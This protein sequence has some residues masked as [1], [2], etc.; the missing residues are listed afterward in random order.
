[1]QAM[2][3]L[4]L[5]S[6]CPTLATAESAKVGLAFCPCVGF[7]IFCANLRWLSDMD[8]K[9]GL[10]AFTTLAYV[11]AIDGAGGFRIPKFPQGQPLLLWHNTM[12][13]TFTQR[14][15][16]EGAYPP[17]GL[18]PQ[19]NCRVFEH[20][21]VGRPSRLLHHVSVDRAQKLLVCPKRT[22][23]GCKRTNRRQNV[24]ATQ[25]THGRRKRMSER[26]SFRRN[27]LRRRRG[28]D[29]GAESRHYTIT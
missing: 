10:T 27:F 26:R 3:Q 8:Q 4:M 28:C 6:Y 17:P 29:F 2:V 13:L 16:G 9:M 11:Q 1:M 25:H 18:K 14:L 15:S 21:P 20:M 19:Q 24:D 7:P 22:D 23:G 12:N 5:M